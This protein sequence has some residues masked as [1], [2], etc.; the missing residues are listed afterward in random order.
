MDGFGALSMLAAIVSEIE[1]RLQYCD[2][3]YL[4]FS[5][6][7][8]SC[9]LLHALSKSEYLKPKI[10]AVHVHHGLSAHATAWQQW[11]QALCLQW[12]IAFYSQSVFVEQK[13]SKSLE[14][15]A[16]EA[17]YHVFES[18]M[19]SSK[20]VML[21][22]H[23]QNDQAETVLLHL[24]RGSGVGGLA[25][26]PVWRPL[27]KGFLYRPFL[28]IGRE[29]LEVYAELHQLDWIDDESNQDCRF[30]R[31][32]IRHTIV[33]LLKERW[34]AVTANLAR[35]TRHCAWARDRVSEWAVNELNTL[36]DNRRLKLSRFRDYT[37]EAQMEL[38]REWIKQEGFR[39]PGFDKLKRIVEE[40]VP[41]R[42]DANPLVKWEGCEIRRYQDYLYA[43]SGSL[44]FNN[45]SAYV[46]DDKSK[47]LMLLDK[48]GQCLGILSGMFLPEDKK[49]TVRF[50]QDGEI[51]QWKGKHR[52]LKKLLNQWKIPPWERDFIPLI[53]F[54]DQLACIPGWA[55]GDDFIDWQE[56]GGQ[57]VFERR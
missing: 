31:N 24:L 44:T 22:A 35:T 2:H 1:K 9:V 42:R 10:T 47:P 33:P 48:T 53:F 21:L 7:L 3:I 16:R 20:D 41:A 23:H 30:D 12:D 43:L 13:N 26:M 52:E 6:G 14:E 54:D 45:T 49:I 57:V 19:Q 27:K 46:W 34:P 50:R 55:V 8:D 32:F 51:I 18:L 56:E 11:A 28:N 40:V 29:K 17:R 36:L 38:L 25:G 4:G 37:K 39:L 15:A 5:G